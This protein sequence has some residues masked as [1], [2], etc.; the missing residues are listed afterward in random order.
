MSDAVVRWGLGL[1]AAITTLLA[2]SLGEL[3]AECQNQAI[4]QAQILSFL[5]SSRGLA[6]GWLPALVVFVV[7]YIA[8]QRHARGQEA[9]RDRAFL[10]ATDFMG[11]FLAG[12]IDD[13]IRDEIKQDVTHVRANIMFDEGGIL[14]VACACGMEVSQDRALTWRKNQGACG[15][16][17]DRS[18]TEIGENRRVPIV[19]IRSE[20][21]VEDMR[22]IWRLTEEHIE[23]TNDVTWVVSI[24]VLSPG[25][26]CISGTIPWCAEHRRSIRLVV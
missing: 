7:F 25:D 5:L 22:R 2:G 8:E 18:L 26:I 14:S 24:P 1:I 3:S 23:K 11:N 13:F 9:A 10:E 19:F 15:V 21:D 20:V 16:A 6:R 4:G 12:M 17:W